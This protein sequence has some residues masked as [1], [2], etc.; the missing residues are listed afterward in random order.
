MYRLLA[1]IKLPGFSWPTC[2]EAD[3]S[4]ARKEAFEDCPHGWTVGY[5]SVGHDG[6]RAKRNVCEKRETI[7]G[8]EGKATFKPV[9]NRT[10]E[11]T[12]RMSRPMREKDWYIDYT[13]AKGLR[14]RAWFNLNM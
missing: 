7:C 12:I 1:S 14:Q 8:T 3:S 6:N 2:P 11:R 9:A 13:D 4:A 10:C 5:R